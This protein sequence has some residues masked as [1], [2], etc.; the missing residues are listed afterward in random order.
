MTLVCVTSTLTV[1]VLIKLGPDFAPLNAS[2][3]ESVKTTFMIARTAVASGFAAKTRASTLLYGFCKYS[4]N[5]SGLTPPVPCFPFF[6]TYLLAMPMIGAISFLTPSSVTSAVFI[7]DASVLKSRP[8][9][10][11]TFESDPP[12]ASPQL[13]IRAPIVIGSPTATIAATSSR[14]AL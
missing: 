13:L 11:V 9:H 4:V 5:T 6:S 1:A 2:F 8:N 12:R 10:A 3:K 14:A 7:R